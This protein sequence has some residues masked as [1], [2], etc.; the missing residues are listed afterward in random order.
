MNITD[1]FPDG[2]LKYVAS[3][4]GGEWFS[5]CPWCGGDDRFRVWPNHPKANGGRYWCRSCERSG[6]AFDLLKQFS[7][8]DN[9]EIL[10]LLG[11]DNSD[12]II[13]STHGTVMTSKGV[14]PVFPLVWQERAAWFI[15][16]CAERMVPDSKGLEYAMSRHLTSETIAMFE[17]GWNPQ[18]KW[19]L[20]DRWGF[21][22]DER[23]SSGGKKVWLPKG[24]V[25]PC[26]YAGQ[27]SGIVIRRKDWQKNSLEPKYVVTSGGTIGL[28]IF[29]NSGRPV[30]VVESALD[31][32]LLW[33]EVR[34]LVDVLA[35]GTARRNIDQA[36]QNYLNNAPLVLVSLDYDETGMR[37]AKAWRQYRNAQY[38]PVPEGKDI[39]DIAD[40]H[41]LIRQWVELGIRQNL[42][43]G[44]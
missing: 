24:L 1:I 14:K 30:I 44:S 37:A 38:W 6:T 34:D 23:E 36:T 26:K 9:W 25:I 22:L 11:K 19:E 15:A 13:D 17:I 27:V 32:I 20:R 39:G 43:A 31:A 42:V 29:S 4:N 5:P 8:L 33:Q 18:D 28:K 41:G 40:K 16:D 21:A 2:T 12:G 7:Q 35:L 10:R 3:T